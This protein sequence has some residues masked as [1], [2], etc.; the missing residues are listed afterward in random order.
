MRRPAAILLVTITVILLFA[1]IAAPYS[2]AKQYRE[3]PNAPVSRQV[4]LG[5]D[6]LGRDRFSR[7]LY[8]G[9]ISLLFAPAAAAVAGLLAL[10]VGL[11]A[12]CLGRGAER[13]VAG[14]ADM[15]VS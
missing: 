9:R 15:C 3:A 12:G 5:T 4:L 6:A 11:L 14:M 1:D 10:M 8:G 13:T 2:Y 7:M